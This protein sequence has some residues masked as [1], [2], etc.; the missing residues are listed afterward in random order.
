ML[1]GQQLRAARAMIGLSVDDLAELTGLSVDRIMD[2]EGA[3]GV[4]TA[5]AERLRLALE[6]K[7]VI[8]LAAGEDNPGGGPGVRLRPHGTEEGIRPQDLSSANDG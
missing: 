4:D 2:A 7:G 3:T 6:P 5:V 1:T 8:F